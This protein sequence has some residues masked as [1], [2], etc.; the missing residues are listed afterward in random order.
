MLTLFFFSLF[1]SY[2]WMQ[3]T[4]QSDRQFTFINSCSEELYIGSQGIPLPAGGGFILSS[5]QSIS[6]TIVGTTIAARFW[7]RTGC[8]TDSNGHLQCQTGGCPLPSEGYT[9]AN[10]GTQ[11]IVAATNT[12]IGGIPPVT[13]AEFTLGGGSSIPNFP[14]YYDL[15]LVDGFNLPV[16]ITPVQGMNMTGLG[17]FSCG[18]SAC[19]A[20]D[21]SKAPPELQLKDSQG[22]VYA[23]ASICI[24]LNNDTQRGLFPD[25][26][27]Q[28][29]T[30]TDP[31]TGYPMKDLLC[32][33]CGD[34]NG[35]CSS[36]KC[37]Y[38]C[39]PYN[40]PSPKEQGGKC[41]I[42]SWPLAS[43]GEPYDAVFSTQ[44]PD[45]YSW[46]FDDH[47]ATFQ[48]I[49]PDYEI[50]FCP[51]KGSRSTQTSKRSRSSKYEIGLN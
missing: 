38:G 3:R 25:I 43:N 24:A 12:Q 4:P 30:A 36:P 48:C 39:S 14:D 33:S 29:W 26:L 27:G 17:R 37:E 1:L 16:Q 9:S 34:G 5:G 23:C 32:C 15:S 47:Q 35:D 21:C 45:A 19:S 20:L 2:G 18:N 42:S 46:P 41:N 28:L 51:T 11:C 44:C 40:L 31:A 6:Q 8:T 50:T 13:I 49:Y 7:A 10:N 22:N